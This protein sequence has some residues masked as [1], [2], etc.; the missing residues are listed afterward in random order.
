M[1]AFAKK[2]FLWFWI[3]ERPAWHCPRGVFFI[4]WARPES[5]FTMQRGTPEADLRMRTIHA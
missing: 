1:V 4:E 3:S 5:Q 2:H